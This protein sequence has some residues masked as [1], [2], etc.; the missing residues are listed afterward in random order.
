MRW[1]PPLIGG[2][3]H[4][5]VRPGPVERLALSRIPIA[6]QSLVADGD[7]WRLHFGEITLDD[8][9]DDAGERTL[10]CRTAAFLQRRLPSQTAAGLLEGQQDIDGFQIEVPSPESSTQ[11]PSAYRAGRSGVG[12]RHPGRAPNGPSTATQVCRSQTTRC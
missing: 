3:G 4:R 9:V 1:P 11:P 5:E 8:V 10:R 12:L 7:K 2:G 6:G